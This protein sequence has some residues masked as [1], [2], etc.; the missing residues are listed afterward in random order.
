[1]AVF[2]R[3]YLDSNVLIASQWPKL[4][5]VLETIFTL[6]DIFRV[7]IYLPKAVEAELEAHWLRIF[8]EK[9]L[10]VNKASVEVN[11]Y[12]SALGEE[13]VSLN[14]ADERQALAAYSKKVEQMKSVWNIK[15]VPLT[16]RSVEELFEIVVRQFSPFN[17][18]DI[19]FKDAVIYFSIIDHLRTDAAHVG[20][21]VSADR[22]FLDVR[23]RGLAK[24]A[25]VS[26]DVYTDLSDLHTALSNRLE[27]AIKVGWEKDKQRAGAA[28]RSREAEIEKF[29]AENLELADNDLGFGTRLVA[30]Q[31]LQVRDITNVQTPPPID[32]KENEPVKLSFD[33]EIELKALVEQ[34]IPSYQPLR[35]KV[36][37]EAQHRAITGPFEMLR[38]TPEN[39][40]LP[41]NVEVEAV[42]PAGDKEYTNIQLLSVRSKGRVVY[43][44]DVLLKQT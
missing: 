28:L 40:S 26:L 36:G 35:L 13:E 32:R 43:L 9:C 23:I 25:E 34:S 44:R 7:E 37:Q 11:K 21:F 6:A 27:E 3:I 29:I 22:I 17:E 8:R 2:D 4:S 12:L 33:V 16:P 30:V 31:E 5:G 24:A 18:G 19:G 20:A 10:K 41:W 1:M 15:N 39:Q 42:S 38:P 14:F